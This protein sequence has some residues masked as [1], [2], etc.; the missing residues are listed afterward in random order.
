MTFWAWL[1]RHSGRGLED[2]LGVVQKHLFLGNQWNVNRENNN[3]RSAFSK[4]NA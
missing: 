4:V 2:I 3:K 1:R